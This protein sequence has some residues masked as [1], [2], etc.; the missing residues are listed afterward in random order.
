MVLNE[1]DQKLKEFFDEVENETKPK[2]RWLKF[3]LF[4]IL[5]VFSLCAIF[6]GVIFGYIQYYKDK[7]YPGVYVGAYHLGGLK[8]DQVQK[9]VESYNDRLSR[10][11]VDLTVK[12]IDGQTASAK[13]TVLS[14]E[15]EE[16]LFRLDSAALGRDAMSAWR[17]GKWWQQAWRPIY[18]RFYAPMRLEVPVL[19]SDYLLRDGLKSALMPFEN[20]AHNASVR[21]KKFGDLSFEVVPEKSGG[22]FVYEKI[23]PTIVEKLSVL[24]TKPIEITQDKFQPT[25]FSQDVEKILP[26][27]KD[28]FSYGELNLN[29]VSPQSQ[30]LHSWAITARNIA[31]WMDVSIDEKNNLIFILNEAQIKKYLDVLRYEIEI[32]PQDAKFAVS[33][34]GKVSEFQASKSGIKLNPNKSY[35]DINNAFKE[36]NFHPAS[37]I[38]TVSITMDSLEPATKIADS[39]DLGIAEIIGSGYSTFFDSHSKRIKNI[40]NAVKRLNGTIIEPGE[41]FSANKYA[42]PYTIENGFVP[43][44]VIKGKEIKDE[45]GGGM[46]Q[47]G[48]T[49]FRMAMNSGMDI[50]ERHNH[51]LVVSYYA[52]PVNRN[53]GTD[54]A[55][56]EPSLDLKFLND[57]GSHLLLETEIDYEKQQLVFTL[58]GKA[59][60]RKGW[61]DHPVVSRWIS[62]GP[63][64]VVLTTKLLYANKTCQPAYR[65][66]VASFTYHRVL[67]TGELVDRVFESYYRP[68]AEICMVKVDAIP[69]G[70]RNMEK[71][72]AVKVSDDGKISTVGETTTTTP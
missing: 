34:D 72:D 32:P 70:C 5:G 12:K 33:A 51:S 35:E 62:P 59:D 40:A 41:V 66:A 19:Y 54:A 50:T 11:G 61:F 24:E 67:P 26:G 37:A 71:C 30:I 1:A 27:V 36:R 20:G 39:N 8:R 55:L 2:R 56:Y 58:W 23:S 10:E 44:A 22:I 29:Y 6:S 17:Q 9:L 18:Y 4:F 25:I 21:L 65:G 68:L 49:L 53:P 60:G 47:I 46:C 57:T 31:E 48:T 7:V 63:K 38:K 42:G 64:E 69:A 43:E 52:D 3:S 45:V 16:D 14:G 28:L 13:L 15:G